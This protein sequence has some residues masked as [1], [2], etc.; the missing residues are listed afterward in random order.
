[1]NFSPDDMDF[2]MLQQMAR[3]CQFLAYLEIH[4]SEDPEIDSFIDILVPEEGTQGVTI[5]PINDSEQAAF[6]VDKATDL[7]PRTY[8]LILQYLNA[9]GHLGQYHSNTTSVNL[10]L[11][12]LVLPP[13]AK[14][15]AQFHQDGHIYSSSHAFNSRIQFYDRQIKAYRTGVINS[16]FEIPLQWNLRKFILVQPDQDLPEVEVRGTPHDPMLHPDFKT[17]LV[18]VEPSEDIL[19]VEPEH[20]ITHL[21]ALKINGEIFGIR[22]EICVVCTALNRERKE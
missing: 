3:L 11:H 7:D 14:H 20:I 16:I 12:A 6:L 19:V 22:R 15:C 10:H 2:T 1:M 13:R 21:S 5:Q 18:E 17:K 4:K 9:T 8:D